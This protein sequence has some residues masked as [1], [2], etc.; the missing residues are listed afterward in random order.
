MNIGRLRDFLIGLFRA[1]QNGLDHFCIMIYSLN[2]QKDFGIRYS[3]YCVNEYLTLVYIKYELKHYSDALFMY[4]N[5][6]FMYLNALFMYLNI[7]L[8][9]LR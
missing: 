8:P 1:F 3:W 9:K 4:L 2:R 6:L 7:H 5:A